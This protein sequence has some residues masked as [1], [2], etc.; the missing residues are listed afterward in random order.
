MAQCG[1]MGG[2]FGL[3]I[4]N[5]Y[6][7]TV[8]LWVGLKAHLEVSAIILFIDRIHAFARVSKVL[9]QYAT[10]CFTTVQL[11]RLRNGFFI[12]VIRVDA[13]KKLFLHQICDVEF[14]ILVGTWLVDLENF[15]EAFTVVLC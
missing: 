15:C 3:V 5:F 11:L 1:F 10:K 13:S 7:L 2:G 4:W 14:Y 9:I 6:V 8:E 12:R